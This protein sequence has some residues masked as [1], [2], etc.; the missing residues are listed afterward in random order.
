MSLA[1]RKAIEADAAAIVRV[2]RAS[3]Y[4]TFV[5]LFTSHDELERYL[6]LTYN[7]DRIQKSISKQN[8]SYFLALINEEVAGFAKIKKT[9]PHE[10]IKSENQSEL[11]RIY[12]LKEY[13]GCGGGQG[14]L[15]AAIKE[16]QELGTGQLWLDVHTSNEKAKRFYEKNGFSK[17]GNHTYTIGAQT[18]DYYVMALPIKV[19]TY[20]I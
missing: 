3:F 6:D 17:A 9:S 8:N 7:A 19:S 10:V 13:H 20:K 18:F 12:V 5:N 14:L 1:V 16:A 15:D 2:G 11:Q 4:D